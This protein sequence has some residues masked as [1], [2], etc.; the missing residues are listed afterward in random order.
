MTSD[1]ICL[2]GGTFYTWG[3]QLLYC[4]EQV[5]MDTRSSSTKKLRV[6]SC[7]RRWLNGSCN[8]F[9]VS[10]HLASSPGHSQ[11]LSCSCGI[12]S[13]SG[14]EATYPGYKVSCQGLPNQLASLPVLHYL[15]SSVVHGES[16]VTV[17][18]K[19]LEEVYESC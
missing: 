12:K 10:T 18:R 2:L 6:G 16:C 3:E 15:A 9:R 17:F 11:I 8:Y 1:L 14:H 4:P 13:G 5:S 19:A 7:R